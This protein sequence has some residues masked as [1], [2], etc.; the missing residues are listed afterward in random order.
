LAIFSVASTFYE[1]NLRR[2]SDVETSKTLIEILERLTKLAEKNGSKRK[3]R[4]DKNT[5]DYRSDQLNPY[6]STNQKLALQ[7][8]KIEL[9]EKKFNWQKMKDIRDTIKDYLDYLESED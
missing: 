5:P 6:A 1:M 7:R 8:R 3:S 2:K 4:N 9:Q